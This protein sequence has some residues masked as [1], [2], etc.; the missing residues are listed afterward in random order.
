MEILISEINPIKYLI[1][2]RKNASNSLKMVI[3][4]TVQDANFFIRSIFK[5]IF[6]LVNLV[7]KIQH[8]QI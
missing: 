3:V 6:N 5:K 1:I 7:Q 4:H 2:K 8:Q